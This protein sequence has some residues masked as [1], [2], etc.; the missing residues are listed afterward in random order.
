[1]QTFS[2]YILTVKEAAGYFNIGEKKLRQIMDEHESVVL[3]SRRIPMTDDVHECFE[4]IIK[5]RKELA[6]LTG[7]GTKLKVVK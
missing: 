5:N 4:R 3:M 7:E 6:Q 2:K 1:M